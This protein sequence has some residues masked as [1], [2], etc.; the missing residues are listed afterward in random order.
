MPSKLESLGFKSI[1]DG[2]SGFEHY[3]NVDNMTDDKLLDPDH[4]ESLVYDTTVDAQEARL[5]DVHAE[6]GRHP[7]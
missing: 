6:P 2:F 1:G 4:P 5:R 3:L 7:R